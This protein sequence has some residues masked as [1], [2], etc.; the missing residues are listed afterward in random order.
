MKNKFL[1]VVL[2]FSLF[3][4]AAAGVWLFVETN[5]AHDE[6]TQNIVIE[7]DG[8]ISKVLEFSKLNLKPGDSCQYTVNLVCKAEGNYNI[9]LE[10]KDKGGA[11]KQY[12]DAK[13]VLDNKTIAEQGLDE[14][15][16]TQSFKTEGVLT[17]DEPAKLVISYEIP[18]SVGN[19]AQGAVADFDIVVTIESK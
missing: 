8:Q 13:V 15:F 19:E 12:V 4:C 10:F 5:S 7:S 3:V 18:L 1:N 16:E 9:T 17:A 14:L 2:I 6:F 11:M